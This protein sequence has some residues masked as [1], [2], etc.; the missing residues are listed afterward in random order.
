MWGVF[1]HLRPMRLSCPVADNGAYEFQLVL[2]FST[3]L[4]CQ[5]SGGKI[6]PLRADY[7]KDGLRDRLALNMCSQW[8]LSTHQYN[9]SVTNLMVVFLERAFGECPKNCCWFNWMP[10]WK[11]KQAKVWSVKGRCF[12]WNSCCNISR[13]FLMSVLHLALL[14][15]FLPCSAKMCLHTSFRH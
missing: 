4:F 8:T 3:G 1:F 10:T 6:L 14:R 15:L 5:L 9:L 2:K 13:Y 7:W 12:F 11:A